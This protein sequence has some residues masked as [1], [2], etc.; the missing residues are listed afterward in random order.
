ME[1][2][3]DRKNHLLE[4]QNREKLARYL[5]ENSFYD[6]KLEQI[7]FLR[8]SATLNEIDD[9]MDAPEQENNSNEDEVSS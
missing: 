5:V 7:Y 3:K 1:L 9:D 4:G 6:E 2:E 8:S